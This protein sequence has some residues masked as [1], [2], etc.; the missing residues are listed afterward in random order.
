MLRAIAQMIAIDIDRNCRS[1]D[2]R[3][4]AAISYDN[5]NDNIHVKDKPA[6]EQHQHKHN[7]QMLTILSLLRMPIIFANCP[8]RL[9]PL[10]KTSLKATDTVSTTSLTITSTLSPS[11]TSSLSSSAISTTSTERLETVFSS[12]ED[13]YH[14]SKNCP[15]MISVAANKY[16]IHNNNNN[17][18]NEYDNN[19]DHVRN[20]NDNDADDED[21]DDDDNVHNH[22]DARYNTCSPLIYAP[23]IKQRTRN[24]LNTAM[25][26]DNVRRRQGRSNA[27]QKYKPN[28]IGDPVGSCL[29]ERHETLGHVFNMKTLSLFEL[30]ILKRW[31]CRI[32]TSLLIMLLLI[33]TIHLDTISADQ[34]TNIISHNPS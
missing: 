29:D 23:S 16:S 18:N 5:Y 27:N 11:T 15:K 14:R 19:D 33:L 25:H 4:V 12:S 6:Q 10:Y 20:S 28:A 26:L 30:S 24:L 1:D 3:T 31:K 34:G 21:G 9:K 7:E 32:Y 8:P 13:I 17:N 22:A 2:S